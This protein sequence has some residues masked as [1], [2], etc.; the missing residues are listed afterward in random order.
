MTS[1]TRYYTTETTRPL[2]VYSSHKRQP[3]NVEA[4]FEKL[5]RELEAERQSVA[6]QLEKVKLGSET[7]SMSSISKVLQDRALMDHAE[8][9]LQTLQHENY[10]MYQDPYSNPYYAD[11]GH[12]GSYARSYS[13]ATNGPTVN[14]TH[15]PHSS[16]MSIHSTHSNNP[17]L[18]GP[19][20][21]TR[22]QAQPEPYSPTFADSFDFADSGDMA[23]GAPSY[24]D[25]GRSDDPQ[26]T[27]TKTVHSTRQPH[28]GSTGSIP[29]SIDR[30]PASPASQP[31]SPARPPQPTNYQPYED[32][33][34]YDD[35]S[36]PEYRNPP[37]ANDGRYG[38]EPPPSGGYGYGQPSPHSPHGSGYLGPQHE[39]PQAS[40]H[41]SDRYG[42]PDDRYRDQPSPQSSDRYGTMPSADRYG[43]Q[44]YG[45]P[46]ND[47]RYR[48]PESEPYQQQRYQPAHETPPMQRAPM[49]SID[50][51]GSQDPLRRPATPTESELSRSQPRQRAPVLPGSEFDEPPARRD[52]YA[53]GPSSMDSRNRGDMKWRSPDLQEVIDYLGHNNNAIVANAAAYLQ[54]LT[55][56]DDPIKNKT[57]GLDG[58]PP[59]VELLSHPIPEI[60]RSACGALRN[61][62]YGKQNEE[63]KVAIKN[64]GGIPALIR[65]LRSTPDVDVRELVTGV[66][67]NLSSAES[68][69]K[70]IID[71]GLAVMTNVVI[72]PES[73]WD[74]NVDEDTKARD[75]PLSTV[76]RNTTGCLRNV[77]SAGPEARTKMRECEGLVDSL[78][79][80]IRSAI[81]KND[82]DNK[83]VENCMC[84]LRN[85]SYR[86]PVEVRHPD[87]ELQGKANQPKQ[88][89]KK[90]NDTSC[91]GG[92]GSKKK[93]DQYAGKIAVD[94]N[95][96]PQRTE[97]AVGM[98][99]LWQPD[100]C[101]PYLSLLSECSNPDTL[102]SA[103]GTIQNLAAADWK[104]SVYI[105]A[106]VRKDK[107]LPVLVELLRMDNDRVVCAV[108]KALRNLSIDPR[109]KELIGKYAM[110]DLV[111]CL[112]GG[113]GEQATKY[114]PST[115]VAVLNCLHEVILRNMENAKS[116]RDASGIEKL[117]TM[118]KS[119]DKY[120]MKI[121]RAAN[122]VLV[123]MWAFKDLRV[124]YKKDGWNAG[125]FTPS[126]KTSTRP[127]PHPASGTPGSTT[128][129]SQSFTSPTSPG[130][131]LE[132]DDTTL[133]KRSEGQGSVYTGQSPQ[134]Y[135]DGRYGTA[136]RDRY[137]DQGQGLYRD[138][139]P[140]TEVSLASPGPYSTLDS[141]ASNASYSRRPPPGAVPM[142]GMSREPQ[143]QVDSREPVYA[144]VDRDKKSTRRRRDYE[145]PHD[146][147]NT[148]QGIALDDSGQQAADSWV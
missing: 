99:L 134:T 75:V 131:G 4:Q 142:H 11:P 12:G 77:S 57:R 43:S 79:F 52:S 22:T 121:V 83:A 25:S 65:L 107:G 132:Y 60:H 128:G 62:S 20:P 95:N 91:F 34:D 114:S 5:T 129:P 61:I 41:G 137:G 48:S 67:W 19:R 90:P 58:I 10:R 136:E 21:A 76:F 74:R 9:P 80:V 108:S 71:D 63:N 130:H 17:P 102:E 81:G 23:E 143:Q 26:I 37:P 1:E 148:S 27:V 70:P 29:R 118:S 84:I 139:I 119:R 147:Q 110:R 117:V 78:M 7:A 92:G 72:I 124:L 40:P 39:P 36:H 68:L 123:T 28:P 45:Q 146:S 125:H 64:A 13:P 8:D 31:Y 24:S 53:S 33:R 82:M 144:Q 120:E 89:N 126:V 15:S 127:T 66:L 51:P 93:K 113:P 2:L 88:Q 111:F 55:F 133:P 59:L 115:I 69:K 42:Y 47:D 14:H 38:D 56:K 50:T 54:H 18:A 116:L 103:A 49:A 135:D 141:Q 16:H 86:M 98:E 35:V 112:P 96:P 104:W 30:Y 138:D 32:L 122:Q 97:P 73:G 3:Y 106:N 46:P 85:L 145:D 101:R 44:P 94:P 6:N 140:M 105:R 100:V 87:N 109:N